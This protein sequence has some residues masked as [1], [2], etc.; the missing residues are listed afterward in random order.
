MLY[1]SF[2]CILSPSGRGPLLLSETEAIRGYIHVIHCS[3][4]DLAKQMSRNKGALAWSDLRH[5]QKTSFFYLLSLLTWP[6]TIKFMNSTVASSW[7]VHPGQIVRGSC[8]SSDTLENNSK[9]SKY[10]QLRTESAAISCL[11]KLLERN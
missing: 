11:S 6:V 8:P 2:S 3:V 7:I 10:I 5:L 1:L 9:F 4:V